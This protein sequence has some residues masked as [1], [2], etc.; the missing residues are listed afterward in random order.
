MGYESKLYFVRDYGFGKKDTD[1]TYSD[2]IAVL[3]MSKM[4]YGRYP[5]V[6][7]F[8]NMFNKETPFSIRVDKYDEDN[9]CERMVDAIEDCYGN[10]LCYCAD[11]NK[12]LRQA[13]KI[14]EETADDPYE[15]FFVMRDMINAF[16][17]MNDVY[18]VH[19]GY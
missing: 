13:N 18:I 14:I 10:R 9:D 17:D 16:K 5:S 7:K 19:Y 6:T 4:G 12:L 15:R 11:K 1:I 3:D 8:V 2:T